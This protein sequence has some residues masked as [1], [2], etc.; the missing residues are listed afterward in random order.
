MECLAILDDRRLGPAI[1]GGEW[2]RIRGVPIDGVD[3]ANQLV[4]LGVEEERGAVLLRPSSHLCLLSI[5]KERG[6][7][8]LVLLGWRV[9]EDVQDKICLK[10]GVILQRLN[11]LGVAHNTAF[12]E[13]D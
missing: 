11:L 12:P 6:L 8:R 4:H 9:R 7:K 13:C 5:G 2:W 3:F 1:N 10:A